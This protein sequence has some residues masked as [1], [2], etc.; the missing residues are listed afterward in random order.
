MKTEPKTNRP[1]IIENLPFLDRIEINKDCIKIYFKQDV[2]PL[3]LEKFKKINKLFEVS[4]DKDELIMHYLYLTGFVNSSRGYFLQLSKRM[5]SK[6]IIFKMI[7]DELTDIGIPQ[8]L[9]YKIETYMNN[10]EGYTYCE[11]ID[12]SKIEDTDKVY[13]NW[14]NQEDNTLT[15][16]ELID[17][18]FET[19][20]DELAELDKDEFINTLKSKPKKKK[21]KLNNPY[22]E[23]ILSSENND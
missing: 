14:I 20:D 8:K 6:D 4:L 9:P 12:F 10:G 23:H 11:T 5:L 19:E 1:L 17:Q 18:Q 13:N 22:L 16:E 21:F 3:R 7:R 2:Q 15:V